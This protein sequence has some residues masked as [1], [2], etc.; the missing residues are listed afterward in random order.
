[1]IGFPLNDLMLALILLCQRAK[2][3]A[4]S[5]PVSHSSPQRKISRFDV[6]EAVWQCSACTFQNEKA[7][8]FCEMC[9]TSREGKAQV[10]T[11]GH[12]FI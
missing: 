2:R 12:F 6:K 4:V 1:V 9:F 7:P 8:E 5:E 3:V 10:P 11:T